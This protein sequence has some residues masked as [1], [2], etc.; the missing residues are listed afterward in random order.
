MAQND[1]YK[2]T[3]QEVWRRLHNKVGDD[4]PYGSEMLWGVPRNGAVIA[5]MSGRTADGPETA[6]V[7]VDDL[8]D[9]GRTRDKYRALFPDKP[10]V[11]LFHKKEPRFGG[12]WIQFPWEPEAAVDI[13]ETVTR[14][15]EYIGEDAAREGLRETPA[16]VVRAWDEMYAGYRTD[17]AA[18]FKTFQEGA[19]R[20]MVVLR[21]VDFYSTCEHHLL[22][23]YGTV[24]IGYLPNERVIGVSKLARLV[25]VFS[26]RLQIQERMTTQIA[27]AIRRHL[28]PDGVMV[29][30]R[31]RHLCMMARG[32]K[33][34]AP[35]MVTSAIRGS[36]EK[37]EVRAEFLS[38]LGP[39]GAGR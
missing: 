14:Q 15:L 29:V 17:P 12:R 32:V 30:C 11:A 24:S 38:I 8:I 13:A 27:E 39:S 16:R 18:L 9:S 23:F 3:W 31:A 6:D 26:R 37:P 33:K 21:E 19:C 2:M 34:Y 4:S 20:E 36:F 7:I 28:E 22:P 5:G 25:D 1:I 10:F 35:E